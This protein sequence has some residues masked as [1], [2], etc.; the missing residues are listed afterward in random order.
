MED[1]FHMV[2]TGNE[3]FFI[4]FYYTQAMDYGSK[5]L[6]PQKI[7]YEIYHVATNEL[8]YALECL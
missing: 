5:V 7:D 1:V 3:L 6:Q 4:N 8:V 2:A